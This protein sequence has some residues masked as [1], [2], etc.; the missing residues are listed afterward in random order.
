[1]LLEPALLKE[2]IQSALLLEPPL[3]LETS[4]VDF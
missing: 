1:M 4:V 2:K 3:V